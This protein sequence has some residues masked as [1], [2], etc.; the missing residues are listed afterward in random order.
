MG[1]R[2]RTAGEPGPGLLVDEGGGFAPG[3]EGG[4]ESEDAIA[5]LRSATALDRK[6]CTV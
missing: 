1:R 5:G 6:R 4:C 3:L 2:V